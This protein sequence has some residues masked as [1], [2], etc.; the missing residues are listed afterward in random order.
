MDKLTKPVRS[1]IRSGLKE[2]RCRLARATAGGGQI[3]MDGWLFCACIGRGAAPRGL[4]GVGRVT[5]GLDYRTESLR[6][7]K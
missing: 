1:V 5:G 4:T 2:G 7:M 3:R 6:R